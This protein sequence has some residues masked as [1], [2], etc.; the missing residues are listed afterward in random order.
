MHDYEDNNQEVDPDFHVLSEEERKYADRERTR[1]WRRGSE[2]KFVVD[3]R[4]PV[5]P[6]Y[7]F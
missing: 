4:V 5:T 1:Q 2:V 3:G 7:R 6:K